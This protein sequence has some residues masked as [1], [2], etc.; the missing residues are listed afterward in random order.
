[1]KSSLCLKLNIFSNKEVLILKLGLLIGCY[2]RKILMEKICR[3]YAPETTSRLQFNFAKQLEKFKF[4]QKPLLE[5]RYFR[6]GLSKIR[7]KSNFHFVFKASL[8]FSRGLKLLVSLSRLTNIF[9][10]FLNFI[11][12]QLIIS[13]AYELFQKSKLFMQVIL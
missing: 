11:F 7:K 13:V 12:H 4:I 1:M 6:R 9:R 8:Y 10:S 2:V 3:K 5:I